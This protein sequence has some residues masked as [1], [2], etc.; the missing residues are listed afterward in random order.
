MTV[1]KWGKDYNIELRAK[2]GEIIQ[3]NEYKYFGEWYNDKRNH[4][5]S[6]KQ[7]KN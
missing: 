7:N 3:T 2:N 6:I 4:V 1:K 5:T